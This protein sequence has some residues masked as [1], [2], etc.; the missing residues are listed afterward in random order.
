MPSASVTSRLAAGSTLLLDLVLVLACAWFAGSTTAEVWRLAGLGGACW[1]LALH[2]EGF[3]DRG[4]RR[5][6]VGALGCLLLAALLTGLG[7]SAALFLSGHGP[8]D[9][10]GFWPFMALSLALLTIEKT[11]LRLLRSRA[12][13][14][15]LYL[16]HVAII[17]SPEAVCRFCEF[18]AA[19]PD[20]GIEVHPLAISGPATPTP[21]EASDWVDRFVGLLNSSTVIDEV[22]IAAGCEELSRFERAVSECTLRGLTVRFDLDS[23][24]LPSGRTRLEFADSMRLVTV[25]RVPVD[26]LALRFKAAMDFVG[27]LVG[28]VL[29]GLAYVVFGPLILLESAGPILFRQQRVGL[30]GRRFNLYKFRTMVAGA[31]TQKMELC[32]ANLMKGPMFK[33]LDDPRVTRLGRF[34]RAYHLD[35]LPQFWNVLTREMSLVG[36]RPPTPDE[37]ASYS[38]HHWRRL[39]VKPGITGPWQLHGNLRVNDFEQVVKLEADYIDRWTLGLDVQI[40]AATLWKL[41]TG[42]RSW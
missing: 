18:A 39:S 31:D 13:S 22:V 36:P 35:E 41:A 11:L 38:P 28:L 12:R 24:G 21:S 16:R 9:V 15:G 4:R 5:P 14:R 19:R 42:R 7:L 32:H 33:V 25:T 27:A 17:G 34:L 3:F 40:L 23:L 2:L 1:L 8:A 29:C 10:P 20:W 26:E 6:A 37:V 30:N